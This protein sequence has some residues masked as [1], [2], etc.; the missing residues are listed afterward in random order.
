MLKKMEDGQLKTL[1]KLCKFSSSAIYLQK[2]KC[3][4]L[5]KNSYGIAEF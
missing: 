1:Q 2:S 3:N 4:G 5:L